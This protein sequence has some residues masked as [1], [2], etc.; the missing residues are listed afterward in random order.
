MTEDQIKPGDTI[1]AKGIDWDTDGEVVDNLPV[2]AT[3]QIP[4]E[5]SEDDIVADLLSD[6]YGWCINSIQA[7]ERV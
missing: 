1:M 2:E 5:W 4:A 3:V 6:Q 7:I